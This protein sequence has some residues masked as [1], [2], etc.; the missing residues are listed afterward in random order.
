MN[1]EEFTR[2]D[3]IDEALKSAQ[4]YILFYKSDP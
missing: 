2:T 1:D 4:N 3:D